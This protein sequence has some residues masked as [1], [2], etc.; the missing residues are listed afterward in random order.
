MKAHL[1]AA[2]APA[3]A[4]VPTL[5]LVSTPTLAGDPDTTLFPIP[6]WQCQTW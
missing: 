1:V 5:A 2:V 4:V 6:V 3:A